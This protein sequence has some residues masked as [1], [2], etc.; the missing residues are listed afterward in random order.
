MEIT[1]GDTVFVIKNH[2][3]YPFTID[4]IKV[5]K[6]N[7]T[8]HGYRKLEHF[9]VPEEYNLKHFN[10]RVIFTNYKDAIHSLCKE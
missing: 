9:A 2:N 10:K 8:A 7:V 1:V 5:F 6:D 4:C 3:I